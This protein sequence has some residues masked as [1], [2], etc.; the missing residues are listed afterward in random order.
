MRPILQIVSV[1]ALIVLTVPSALFLA[2]QMKLDSV[3]W[4][5]LVATIIW[6]VTA[7]PWMWTDNGQQDNA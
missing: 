7:T 2:G 5:M 1:V 6:F 3:K 4:L